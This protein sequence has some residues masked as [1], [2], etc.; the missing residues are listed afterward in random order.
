M[1]G[2]GLRNDSHIVFYFIGDIVTVDAERRVVDIEGLVEQDWAK[3]KMNWE[4]RP[5]H[6]RPAA[7]YLRKYVQLTSSASLGCVTDAMPF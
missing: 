3:R 7:G 2:C 5:R 1:R 6:P 4:G